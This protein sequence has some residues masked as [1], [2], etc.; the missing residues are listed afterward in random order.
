VQRLLRVARTVA[1]TDQRVGDALDGAVHRRSPEHLARER[2]TVERPECLELQGWA[3]EVGEREELRAACPPNRVAFLE[4]PAAAAQG[5]GP[6]VGAP[7]PERPLP[8]MHLGG[9]HHQRAVLG[10]LVSAGKREHAKDGLSQTRQFLPGALRP[11][12]VS[13]AL[14]HDGAE[15]LS[16]GRGELPRPVVRVKIHHPLP[17]GSGGRSQREAPRP[18]CGVA[19]RT[20]PAHSRA[21]PS[22]RARHAWMP[23]I[24]RSSLAASSRPLRWM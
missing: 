1:P 2:Q 18:G 13:A 20:G 15:R 22:V 21:S 11:V 14:R 8:R 16:F 17:V 9:E 5:L 12:A 7:R 19:L 6:L 10:V 3:E 4:V 23:A 24:P